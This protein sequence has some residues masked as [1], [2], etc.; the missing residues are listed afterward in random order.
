MFCNETL[1][2]PEGTVSTGALT[3]AV[4]NGTPVPASCSGTA[5]PRTCTGTGSP[6]TC[7]VSYASASLATGDHTVNLSFAGDANY[8]PV[9][10]TG[11]LTVAAISP[12][13]TFTVPN[14]T[15]GDTP[16]PVSASSNRTGNFTY[17]VVS[18]PDG[19][20]PYGN[21]HRRVGTVVLQATQAASTDYSAAS[22]KATSLSH[23]PPA[24]ISVSSSATQLIAAKR[25]T[26]R[27]R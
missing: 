21:A 18:G 27:G 25:D 5:S 8:S 2:G 12:T 17:S 23:R 10:G 7:T 9:S 24:V 11:T 15:F 26:H 19:I 16:F 6:V 14:H 1:N 3:F 4:Q 20:R 13:L 22:T